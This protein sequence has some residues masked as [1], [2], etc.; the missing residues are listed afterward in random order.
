MV[1]RGA[2][3]AGQN[4]Q[5][6]QL[7][8]QRTQG[9]V[10]RHR[11]FPGNDAKIAKGAG[12]DG[13]RICRR[14]SDE[15]EDEPIPAVD[16]CTGACISIFRCTRPRHFRHDGPS[17]HR[18]ADQCRSSAARHAHLFPPIRTREGIN[19][20]YQPDKSRSWRKNENCV[21]CQVAGYSPA[22]SPPPE[23]VIPAKPLRKGGT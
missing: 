1:G 21:R 19:G 8:G 16:R 15:F 6:V 9:R 14:V 3:C 23:A 12:C 5:V 17:K 18:R 13:W 2:F 7:A 11:C 10:C 22:Y 4:S 20:I